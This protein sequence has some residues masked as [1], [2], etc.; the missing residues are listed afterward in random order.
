M[1]GVEAAGMKYVDV[2]KGVTDRYYGKKTPTK[3]LM[4]KKFTKALA[5]SDT[6][7]MIRHPKHT[8]YRSEENKTAIEKV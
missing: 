5:E 2:A 3:V 8:Y 4:V 7:D 6:V 1:D